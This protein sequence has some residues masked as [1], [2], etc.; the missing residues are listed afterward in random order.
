MSKNYQLQD[1]GSDKYSMIKAMVQQVANDNE[2]R[3]VA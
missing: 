1:A 3:M 2:W